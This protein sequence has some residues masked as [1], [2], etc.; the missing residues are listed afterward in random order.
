MGM[1]LVLAEKRTR[2][3][4]RQ[5]FHDD[6]PCSIARVELFHELLGGIRKIPTLIISPF[7]IEHY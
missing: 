3:I 2:L 6:L 4:A 7:D 1:V 5:Q